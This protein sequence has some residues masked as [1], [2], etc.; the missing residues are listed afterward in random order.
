MVL[1]NSK[2]PHGRKY[3]SSS[4]APTKLGYCPTSVSCQF[5]NGVINLLQVQT[6]VVFTK[7]FALF[8]SALPLP[9]FH[10][11]FCNPHVGQ[12][13]ENPRLI[14]PMMV[15]FTGRC[16]IPCIRL[17]LHGELQVELWSF[18]A[19]SSCL[20]YALVPAFLIRVCVVIGPSNRR[21]FR[22]NS[23]NV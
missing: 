2:P 21:V 3:F 20:A 23:N 11:S 15:Y 17:K 8:G 5:S 16:V 9:Q 6:K 12:G 10:V 18:P 14:S 19:N 1:T 13:G 22:I 4:V 7:I